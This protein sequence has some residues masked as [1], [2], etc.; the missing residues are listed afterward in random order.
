[1]AGLLTVG[2]V[3]LAAY[4][5]SA[6]RKPFALGTHDCATFVAGWLARVTGRPIHTDLHAAVAA[7]SPQMP[8]RALLRVW[9]A[10]AAANGLQRTRSPRSGDVGIVRD[11]SAAVGAVLTPKGWAR[12]RDRALVVSRARCVLAWSARV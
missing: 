12:I 4:L 11:G 10:A 2:P 6:S 7:S 1:M 5:R 9:S 3:D 8:L